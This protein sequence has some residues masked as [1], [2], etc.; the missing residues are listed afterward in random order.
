[1]TDMSAS[2]AS[3]GSTVSRDARLPPVRRS[4]ST[5]PPTTFWCWS[6]ARAERNPLAWLM[7]APL[8]G[9][10]GGPSEAGF[11]PSE[12][13]ASPDQTL[14]VSHEIVSDLH[15]QGQYLVATGAHQAGGRVDD[16]Q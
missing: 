15:R 7:T 14:V 1:M 6:A 10:E 9:T 12:E 13:P 5:T 8:D 16:I 4:C 3:C 2:N 11:S